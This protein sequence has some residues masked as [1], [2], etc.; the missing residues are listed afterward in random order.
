MSESLTI[1]FYNLLIF[2]GLILGIYV[3]LKWQIKKRND[4]FLDRLSQNPEVMKSFDPKGTEKLCKRMAEY[5]KKHPFKAL[6][7]KFKEKTK[8]LF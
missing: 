8:W 4:A 6:K 5:D 7:R 1:I 3:Y 2:C